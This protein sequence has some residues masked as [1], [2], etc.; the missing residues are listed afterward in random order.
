MT[1]AGGTDTP[2]HREAHACACSVTPMGW[3]TGTAS[4]ISSAPASSPSTTWSAWGGGRRPPLRRGLAGDLGPALARR[5]H[6]PRPRSRGVDAPYRVGW[7][8]AVTTRGY[9][10]V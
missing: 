3:P 2:P 7:L 9:T 5:D 1:S 8:P 6:L 4:S 10:V